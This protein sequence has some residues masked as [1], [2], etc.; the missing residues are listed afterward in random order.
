MSDLAIDGRKKAWYKSVATPSSELNAHWRRVG[1]MP[2]FELGGKTYQTDE[3]GYLTN[4][5]DWSKDVALHLAKSVGIG[6]LTRDHWDVVNFLK[7][8]YSE[9]QV[10]PM[11]KILTKAMADK[12]GKDKKEVSKYLYELFPAGPA[13][14]ACK[15]AGLPKPTGC[16]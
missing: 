1:K 8:Y 16:V 13:K 7:D 3:E 4:P 11:I 12:M 6:D 15:I 9:Y 5:D 2:N 10:A 14:D